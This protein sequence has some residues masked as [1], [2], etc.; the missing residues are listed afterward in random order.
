M[1]SSHVFAMAVAAMILAGACEAGD[2]PEAGPSV[3]PSAD[4][5]VLPTPTERAAV[6][7]CTLLTAEEVGEISDREIFDVTPSQTETGRPTC[8]YRLEFTVIVIG[9]DT[10]P[11]AREEF[12]SASAAGRPVEGVGDEAYWLPEE[13]TLIALQN[14]LYVFVDLRNAD[15]GIANED[16]AAGLAEAALANA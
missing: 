15:I 8:E 11:D 6:D 10:G 13:T 9:T 3:S 16:V 14:A 4:P 7:P 2:S 5:D 12:E 1:R